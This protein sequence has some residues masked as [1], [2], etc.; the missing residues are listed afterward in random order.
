MGG[1]AASQCE[2]LQHLAE[3]PPRVGRAD[4]CQFLATNL[5]KVCKRV[6]QRVCNLFC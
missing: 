3:E 1:K 5:L 2:L 4:I 6:L